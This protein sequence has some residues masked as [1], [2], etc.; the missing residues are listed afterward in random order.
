[1]S[2]MCFRRHVAQPLAILAIINS[3]RDQIEG[4]QTLT[5]LVA[6]RQALYLLSVLLCALF[7][8]GFLFVDLFDSG[9][10]SRGSGLPICAMWLMAPETFVMRVSSLSSCLCDPC[11]S[12]FAH[13]WHE[14]VVE[15]V[16]ESVAEGIVGWFRRC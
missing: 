1:M 12:A 7:N 3:H 9:P 10:R 6:I 16:A 14:S 5:L 8:P 2:R 13:L 15:S 11:W 4:V